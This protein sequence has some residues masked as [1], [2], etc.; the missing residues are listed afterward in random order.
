ML[1]GVAV[2]KAAT[3]RM[4]GFYTKSSPGK[5]GEGVRSGAAEI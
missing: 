3:G 5:E 1:P 2:D 4:Y